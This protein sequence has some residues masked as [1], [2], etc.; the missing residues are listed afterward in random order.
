MA[1]IFCPDKIWQPYFVRIKYGSHILSSWTKSG[2]NIW[3]PL[4]IFCPTII[5]PIFF[6]Q[7]YC[8]LAKQLGQNITATFCPGDYNAPTIFY[9]DDYK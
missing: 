5:I 6:V 8:N 2:C 4:A 1:A 3:S 9:L 7:T